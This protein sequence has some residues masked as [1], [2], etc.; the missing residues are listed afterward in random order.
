MM[1]PRWSPE[2]RAAAVAELKRADDE[3]ASAQVEGL[4]C[5]GQQLFLWHLERERVR[6][7]WRAFFQDW[8]AMLTPAFHTPAFVHVAFD[9][10]A[11]GAAATHQRVVVAGQ[12]LPYCR[13]LFYPHLST[14]AGQPALACPVGLSPAGLPLSLQLVGPYLEDLTLTRLGGLLARE[15]GGFVP[16]PAFS[17]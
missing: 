9:G 6:A 11:L 1:S 10:P 16:P 17:R 2:K 7:A 4:Q 5:T 15:I 3:F 12:N 14:L 8:D 13:G